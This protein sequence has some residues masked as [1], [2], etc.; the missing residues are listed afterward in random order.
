MSAKDSKHH[1]AASNK[2]YELEI[3]NAT[4]TKFKSN[5]LSFFISLRL[6]ISSYTLRTSA[7]ADI[8]P[9]VFVSRS[10]DENELIKAKKSNVKIAALS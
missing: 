1:S 10:F 7:T 5:S 4:F 6:P 2:V 3:K 8:V 9:A